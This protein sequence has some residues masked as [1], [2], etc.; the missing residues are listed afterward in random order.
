MH[1]LQPK[2][3]KLKPSEAEELLK[4]LNVSRTQLPKILSTDAALPEDVEAGDIIKI[5]RHCG[6]EKKEYYRIVV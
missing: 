6:K 3:V 1:V 5:E 4:K 2:Q